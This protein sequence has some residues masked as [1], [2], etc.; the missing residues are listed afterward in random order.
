[1]R[2][3]DF[4][5]WRKLGGSEETTPYVSRKREWVC[6]DI[7][8]G[9]GAGSTAPLSMQRIRW[10]LAVP[11]DLLHIWDRDLLEWSR[12]HPR[13]C[14]LPD[15]SDCRITAPVSHSLTGRHGDNEITTLHLSREAKK[16]GYILYHYYL[17]AV[18]LQ[19]YGVT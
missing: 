2:N 15:V 5:A 11:G 19:I 18:A 3:P 1:M 7:I 12:F 13:C 6:I 4:C 14:L 10:R 9:V 17:L 8:A 16:L